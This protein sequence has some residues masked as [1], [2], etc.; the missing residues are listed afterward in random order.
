MYLRGVHADATIPMLRQLIRSNPLGILTTAITSSTYPFIQSSHIPFILDV[1]DES[2]DTEL[3]ILRG[4]IA[5]QN[6]Q[7]KAIIDSLEA[8]PQA[9]VD[10]LE[11][12]VLVLFNSP[13]H[14]YV[15][16]KFYVET[17]PST[18]K[19]VPT[20]NYAAAQ[21]YG[22]A[23][24]YYDS[25]SEESKNFLSKQIRDLSQYAETSIMGYTGID[26]PGPWKVSD[27]PERYIELL[28]KNIIGIEIS[29]ERL[30]GKFKMS[31]EMGQGDTDGVIKGFKRLESEIGNEMARVVEERRDLKAAR[32]AKVQA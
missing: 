32:S 24:V 4:H 2:S 17:K 25:K 21:A 28:Q 11:Q 30:E 5:R 6:P 16:P 15:T 8:Q 19:V 29:I 1:E 9:G 31:Q 12:E 23:R 26:K 18:G 22:R 10:I 7:S 20:W 27:A 14:H 3:G 13:V